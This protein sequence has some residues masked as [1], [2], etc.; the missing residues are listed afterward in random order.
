MMENVAGLTTAR[1]R[2]Y[3][4]K[5][6]GTLEDLGYTVEWR[7]LNAA[8]FGVP[9]D[10]R[11]LIVLGSRV[12]QPR[13]PEPTHGPAAGRPWVTAGEALAHVAPD[14]PNTAII[15]YARRPILRPS[16]F[17]GMLV[18]GGGRPIDLSR[19]S[20]T[21]PASAG[22]NRTHIY[23]PDGILLEYHRELLSGGPVRKGRVAG[24]RR[25]TVRESAALQSFPE[26]FE[27]LGPQSARYSQVGNAVPPLL[28]RAVGQALAG[29]LK[30]ERQVVA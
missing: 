7:I 23:D 22:G 1:H 29:A 11:R 14:V 20:Q 9:Q 4:V 24:V 28:A 12:G 18:N 13:F 8:D 6:L 30:K 17:A 21:I 3:L 2:D 26:S 5:T 27:F 25:I 15:T 10:R 16:P 19:P